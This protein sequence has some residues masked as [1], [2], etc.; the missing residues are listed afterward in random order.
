[1]GTRLNITYDSD[2]LESISSEFDLRE[3]NKEALRQLIS[4]LA[5]D[6]DPAV[7]QVLSLATGVGKTYLMAAFIEYLRRHGVGNVVIVTPGKTVQAKTVQ[8]FSP[9]SPRYITGSSVPPDIVTPQDYSA[10]ITRQNG[11]AQLMFGRDIPSLAFI[12]NIQQLIAPKSADG[13]THGTNQDAMRRKPRRFDENAGVLFDYLRDL[14]D[15]VVIADESHLYGSSA[16]A[17]N[18]ALTELD[19]AVTVGLT[20]SANRAT[21]HVIYNYPLYR[22]IQDKYV[23]APVLAFRK[24]GYGT[25]QASEEQQLRDALQLRDIKQAYYESYAASHNRDQVNAV[26]FV[27]CSDVDHATQVADLLRTPEYLGRADAVLQVDSKHEDEL[28]QRR[29]NELD[30]P[31]SPVRA[32]VSVNKLK[33]GWDVKNIA[34]VVTLRAMSSEVLTQQTMGRGLRLPFGRYTDV[35]QIDQ[36]DIIAHQSFT[37]L[38]NAENVLQQFGLDD[39]VAQASK[40][41]VDEAIRTA[42][43]AT[44]AHPDPENSIDDGDQAPGANQAGR[45]TPPAPVPI[46]GQDNEGR[47]LP[48]LGIRSITDS[49]AAGTGHGTGQEWELVTIER[50]PSLADVTYQFPVTTIKRVQPPVDLFTITETMIKDAASRVTSAGDVL[51]RKEIIAALGKKL[52]VED[53]ESAEVDSIRVD[54]S[55]AQEAL[56]TLVMNMPLVKR[57]PDARRFVTTLLVPQFMKN[58]SFTG[59]T[60]KS[61][62]S[63]ETEIRKL[64]KDFTDDALRSTHDV[65][66]I[67]PRTLPGPGHTL[68]LGERVHDQIETRGQFVRNRVYGGWFKSLFPAE[69]FDSFSGEYELARLLNTS[70]GIK[71]WHRLHRQD[72]AFVYYNK[73]DR[74]YPDFVA[75]DADGVHWIIEGKAEHGRDDDTVQAKRR[76]A[77]TLVRRLAVN[78][79]YA[80]QHWGYLI[81]YESDIAKADSW[82]DLKTFAQPVSNKY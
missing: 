13:D 81:A 46:G 9:G 28:T 21:D 44:G 52:R 34:V 30:R 24:A 40:A 37:E 31:D 80:G 68:P 16:V 32:V 26:A 76:A 38:L 7:M 2:M 70:P 20:A 41:A 54:D 47:G 17:F 12:F 66:A 8:N 22:A 6:Y 78:D 42:A 33:E 53:R 59:W 62:A 19:P 43:E 65:P 79:D 67:E 3:P 64:V 82:E 48:G 14:D 25:D 29:L 77:E 35:W 71:W 36:L 15:L 63:A 61:V 57:S 10:W 49:D 74:Y 58:V 55:V 72:K 5:G 56:V 18:A 27:V 45:E 69:S 23:K 39:A 1:M 73:M 51:L 60:A 11:S 75:C 50:N 4:T